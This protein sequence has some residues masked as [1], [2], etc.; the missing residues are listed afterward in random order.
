MKSKFQ[1][2]PSPPKPSR[3]IGCISKV[4]ARGKALGALLPP[5]LRVKMSMNR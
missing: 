1:S 4:S 3:Y 2:L 5:K